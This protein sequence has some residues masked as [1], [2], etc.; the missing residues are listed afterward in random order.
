MDQIYGGKLQLTGDRAEA[1]VR[2]LLLDA[3]IH[4]SK[5]EKDRGED[6]LIELEGY[7][8]ASPGSIEPRVGILQIKGHDAESDE[9]PLGDFTRRRIKV[10]KLKRWAAYPLPAFLIAV[11]MLD[12]RTNCYAESVD[13]V[14]SEFAPAG[15]D[16]LN[17]VDI[18][19]RMPVKADLAE[20]LRDSIAF[21]Y[22]A[23]A[24]QLSQLSE[25]AISRSHF[26]VLSTNT[27]QF[28]AGALVWMKHLRILWKGPWRPAHFWAM[29][30]NIADSLKISDENRARPL[31]A[32]M[33]VYRSLKD[34]SDNNAIAHVSW[35]DESHP[36]KDEIRERI[37]WPKAKHW[38]RFRF[39]TPP[40]LSELPE[41]YVVEQSDDK[42]LEKTKEL[43]FGLDR[44]V[45]R[46]FPA[47]NEDFS[48]TCRAA[49]SFA[50]RV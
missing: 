13:K 4:C 19:I 20:F 30:N 15:L 14:V 43:W 1:K 16:S 12:V 44:I 36:S 24:F 25:D 27:S 5:F 32:T 37:E 33:H 48:N 2:S 6:L 26:E 38:L 9:R 42:Y 7:A 31:L 39:N 22:D 21:F 46:I 35:L 11:D 50:D 8:T 10:E 18:T 17:Q 45:D 49:E 23:H 41:T 28:S 47:L 29:L 40:N 34:S 3:G